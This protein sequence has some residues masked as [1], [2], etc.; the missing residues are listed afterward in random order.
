MFVPKSG[1]GDNKMECDLVHYRRPYALALVVLLKLFSEV[2]F[3]IKESSSPNFGN[4][5]GKNWSP[6]RIIISG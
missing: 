4:N 3:Q 1:A 2:T 6:G 5:F